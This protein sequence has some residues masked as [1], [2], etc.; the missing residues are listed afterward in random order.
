MAALASTMPSILFFLLLF[1]L[2]LLLFLFRLLLLLGFGNFFD[3]VEVNRLLFL[4]FVFLF[5]RLRFLLSPY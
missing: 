4:S 5:L 2:L 1:L 3:A